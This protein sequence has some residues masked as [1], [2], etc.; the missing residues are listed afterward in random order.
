MFDKVAIDQKINK[1]PKMAPIID[2]KRI[3]REVG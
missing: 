3:S 2:R 1:M